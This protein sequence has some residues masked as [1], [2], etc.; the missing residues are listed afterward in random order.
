[1][2]I[3]RLIV[4]IKPSHLDFIYLFRF[5]KIIYGAFK[6]LLIDCNADKY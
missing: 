5:Y 3:R 1:M 4:R 2:P 6:A